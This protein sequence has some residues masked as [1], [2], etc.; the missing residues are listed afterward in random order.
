MYYG[1]PFIPFFSVQ[2]LEFATINEL[3]KIPKQR[4]GIY[5]RYVLEKLGR[6][7]IEDEGKDKNWFDKATIFDELQKD[8]VAR[9]DSKCFVDSTGTYIVLCM[10]NM[11]NKMK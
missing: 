5:P 6:T 8:L 4:E 9:L 11:T 7:W 2:D 10:V 1:R 3:N